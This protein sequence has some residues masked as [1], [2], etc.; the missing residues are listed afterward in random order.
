MMEVVVASGKGGTG[1]TFIASNLAYWLASRGKRVVAVDCDV[2]AP[3]LALA[4]GGCSKVLTS[5]VVAE[6]RKARIDKR[7]CIKCA[8]C[9]EVCSFFAIEIGA[10]GYPEVKQFL[11][12]GCGA[13]AIACPAG[14]ITLE[15]SATGKIIACLSGAGIP[16]VTGD[17]EVGGRNSGHLVYEAK[18]EAKRVLGEVRG[19]YLVVDSAPGIGCP[20]I[21]S[22]SGADLLLV[23]VEPT[24]QS[25]QGARRLLEVAAHF[26]IKAYAIV[27]KAGLGGVEV[28]VDRV[29]G[30]KVVGRVPYDFKAMEAY[31]RLTPLLAYAPGSPAAKALLE[32]FKALSEVIG[33]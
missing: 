28:E 31:A 6:S 23:V 29:L 12:D 11:C 32:S 25:L 9:A 4:L 14:A 10:E 15:V 30:V 3:D 1:K 8:R 18:E 24:R 2:E 21:S 5:R 17:L 22:L 33:L 16:V 26:G 19:D 20:V 7:R 27:N 13:C